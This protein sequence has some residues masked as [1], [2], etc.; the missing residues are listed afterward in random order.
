MLLGVNPQWTARNAADRNITKLPTQFSTD[1]GL[2]LLAG[3]TVRPEEVLLVEVLRL[4]VVRL[5]V[6]YF[7]LHVRRASESLDVEPARQVGAVE[8]NAVGSRIRIFIWKK[9][10]HG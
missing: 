5:L 10:H 6:A 9:Q 2:R 7:L 3:G 1:L 4:Y 8:R